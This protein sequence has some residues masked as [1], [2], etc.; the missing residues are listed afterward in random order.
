MVYITPNATACFI[1]NLPGQISPDTW[2]MNGSDVAENINAEGYLIVPN[3]GTLFGGSPM[4]SA[5]TCGSKKHNTS[6]TALV[7]YSGKMIEVACHCPLAF[8][9]AEEKCMSRCVCMLNA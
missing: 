6:M 4:S 1:C 5:L 3:P 2:Q 7:R 8:Y 9:C